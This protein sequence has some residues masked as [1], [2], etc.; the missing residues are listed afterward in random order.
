M[1][2]TLHFWS[3]PVPQ[4][5]AEA[6]QIHRRLSAE[7]RAKPNS[8]FRRLA[9]RLTER[10]PCITALADGDARAVWSGGPLDGACD[11]GVY[12]IGLRSEHMAEVAPFVV[13]TA[14]SMGLVAYDYLNGVVWLPGGLRLQTDGRHVGDHLGLPLAGPLSP[15]LV[16]RTVCDALEPLFALYGIAATP[17][18]GGYRR[19]HE[20]GSQLIRYVARDAGEGAVAFDLEVVL[21][22]RALGALYDHVLAAAGLSA[23]E[24]FV[25]TA[26]ASFAT[27]VRFQRMQCAAARLRRSGACFEVASIEELR[28][29]AIDLRQFVVVVLQVLLDRWENPNAISQAVNGRDAEHWRPI[30]SYW[31]DTAD[32][33]ARI[34]LAANPLSTEQCGGPVAALLLAG[35]TDTPDLPEVVER[36]QHRIA[37]LEPPRQAAERA[38]LDAVLDSLRNNG[39][40]G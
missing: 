4:T 21:V 36:T 12:G 40:L 34:S 7:Q 38:K 1:S 31:H 23:H 3:F 24:R 29:A 11:S 30:G 9:A 26:I 13:E 16:Q 39:L 25:A 19:E 33:L 35:V 8:A 6:A 27:L 5:E 18:A 37:A 14:T 32:G 20:R 15:A 10:H 2:Y 28:R 17:A 22:D